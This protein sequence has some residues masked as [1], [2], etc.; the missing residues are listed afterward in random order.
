MLTFNELKENTE[1]VYDYHVA[2]KMGTTHLYRIQT[3]EEDKDV[4]LAMSPESRTGVAS[5]QKR[6][7]FGTMSAMKGRKGGSPILSMGDPS[8]MASTVATIVDDFFVNRRAN[9]LMLRVNRRGSGKIWDIQLKKMLKKYRLKAET[10]QLMSGEDGDARGS[11]S[12]FVISRPSFDASTLF[13]ATDTQIRKIASMMAREP[14]PAYVTVSLVVND[15][16]GANYK[17]P[18]AILQWMEDEP[19]Q[20]VSN[21]TEITLGVGEVPTFKIEQQ[22][23]AIEN[24]TNAYIVPSMFEPAS[25]ESDKQEISK[26]SKAMLGSIELNADPTKVANKIMPMINSIDLTVSKHKMNTVRKMTAHLGRAFAER[27]RA[28]YSDL[29]TAMEPMMSE[30]SERERSALSEYTADGFEEINESLLEGAEEEKPVLE[31]LAIDNAFGKVGV[32]M[33]NVKPKTP[34]YRGLAMEKD[35]VIDMLRSRSFASLAYMSASMDP[36]IAAQ[37]SEFYPY[38]LVPTEVEHKDFIDAIQNTQRREVGVVFIIDP[39]GVPALIPERLVH[40]T[41]CEFIINRGVT[42]KATPISCAPDG[43][44]IIIRLSVKDKGAYAE[45]L[46]GMVKTHDETAKLVD[47]A[48]MISLFEPTEEDLGGFAEK[49]RSR[50]V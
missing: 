40:S 41:E 10:T 42:F 3:P 18:Q 43:K 38:R 7:W 26:L 23:T 44:Y 6:V 4:V 30:L 9:A 5:K 14:D 32:N 49:Q 25:D 12:F 11:Y 21:G 17:N 24:F 1:G 22:K 31:I 34:L 47:I 15:I 19:P 27:S 28:Q 39:E 46:M 13:E 50:I 35:A 29:L 16:P 36:M 2:R 48:D 8:I 20:I 45:S 37:F 33:S